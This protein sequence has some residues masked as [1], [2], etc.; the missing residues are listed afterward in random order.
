MRHFLHSSLVPALPLRMGATAAQTVLITDSSG[1]NRALPR[2]IS[3]RRG[4]VAVAAITVATDQY[5]RAA[6]GAQVVSSRRVHWQSGPMESRRPRPL[7]EILCLQRRLG[8]LRGTTSELAWRLGPVSC[9]RFHRPDSVLLHPPIS[10]RASLA[11]QSDRFAITPPKALR[12]ATRNTGISIPE[13]QKLQSPQPIHHYGTPTP[14]C[15]AV[16]APLTGGPDPLTWAQ[17]LAEGIAAAQRVRPDH[18]RSG[19]SSI[20]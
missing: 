13:I 1:A 4:A 2:L 14:N 18:S 20:I 12:A 17:T 8:E 16:G 10:C 11:R 6:T 7:R 15:Y 9:L 5:G 3:A 19:L